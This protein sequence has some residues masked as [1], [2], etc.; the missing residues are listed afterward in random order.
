MRVI[1]Q[2]KKV[3]LKG[4]TTTTGGSVLEGSP[5]V[6]QEDALARKGGLVFCPACKAQ[7]KIT[8]GSS[9]VCI[10]GE[11]EVALEGHK[12]KCGCP[13]GCRLVALG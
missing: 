13:D 6:N 10:D 12:V 5:L 4:D 9:L 3:I 7:G 8:E 2:G 11:G 1:I